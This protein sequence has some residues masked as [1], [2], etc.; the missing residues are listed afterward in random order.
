M[1]LI[2]ETKKQKKNDQIIKVIEKTEQNREKSKKNLQG[3]E[4]KSEKKSSHDEK[5]K[6]ICQ[7]TLKENESKKKEIQLL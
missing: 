6:E 1:K 7:E 5:R 2:S 4:I 3:F